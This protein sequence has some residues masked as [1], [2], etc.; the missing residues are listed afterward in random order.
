MGSFVGVGDVNRDGYGDLLAE[1][2]VRAIIP[3]GFGRRTSSPTWV[4]RRSTA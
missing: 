3:G 1:S 2:P 4:V